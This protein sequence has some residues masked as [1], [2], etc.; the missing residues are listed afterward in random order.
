MPKLEGLA[1]ETADLRPIQERS[2]RLLAI[3]ARQNYLHVGPHLRCLGKYFLTCCAGN[4]HIQ[5]HR[6]NLPRTAAEKFDCC[7]SIINLERLKS[8]VT[9]H[10]GDSQAKRILIF[11]N[12][13][14]RLAGERRR[15]DARLVEAR[16]RASLSRSASSACFGSLISVI[17]TALR[18]ILRNSIAKGIV[19]KEWHTSR[20]ICAF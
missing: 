15:H 14:R 18:S 17:A 10:A 7:R 2:C 5:Q 6:V 3:S 16:K 9:Q 8:R 11:H 20:V 19:V 13:Y 12:Q 1:N 4:R